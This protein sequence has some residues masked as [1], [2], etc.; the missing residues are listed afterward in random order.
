MKPYCIIPAR[1]NSKGLKNKNVLFF[2]DKPL[3]LHTVDQAI[4]SELFDLEDI[5]VSSDSQEYLDICDTRGVTT[6]KRPAELATDYSSSYDVLEHL[7]KTLDNSRPFVLLQVTSPLRTSENIR[8]SYELFKKSNYNTVVS[9]KDVGV[10]L[11]ITTRL[12]SNNKIVDAKMLDKGIRRQDGDIYYR[13][14]GAIYIAKISEY[15]KTGSFL[16]PDTTAYIMGQNNSLDIDDMD[17]F[18]LASIYKKS[19]NKRTKK[20][21]NQD[22]FVTS[23]LNCKRDSLFIGDSRLKKISLSGHDAVFEKN[24]TIKS[25]FNNIDML[26]K[27]KSIVLS[28][29]ID[30]V[31]NVSLFKSYFK[32]MIKYCIDSNQKIIIIFPIFPSYSIEYNLLEVVEFNRILVDLCDRNNIEYIDINP[33]ILKNGVLDFRYSNDGINFNDKGFKKIQL[34]IN[35]KLNLILN[36]IKIN[37]LLPIFEG[38]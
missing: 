31:N 36:N 30:E 9:M 24:C 1:G 3:I 23:I 37:K 8:E 7:F 20:T 15:L 14:N 21:F 28:I 12:D 17:D 29:N 27:F 13:P 5:I 33:Y 26:T 34:C 11:R 18:I 32:K 38:E 10:D 16:T 25:I 2:D 35:K 4:E 19:L 22:H 6:L